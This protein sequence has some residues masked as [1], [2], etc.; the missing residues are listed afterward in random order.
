MFIFYNYYK[1]EEEHLSEQLFLEMKNYSFFFDD[2]R[3]DI[4]IVSNENQEQFYELYFNSKSLY[5]L[6]PLGD[7]KDS[8]LKIFYSTSEYKILLQNIQ[9]AIL[10]RFGFLSLIAIA[11]SFLF[12][13][14]ALHPLRQALQLL[15][16]F[17][18]DI[19]H[20]LNTPLTSILINIKM[21]DAKSE[22]V[23]SIA[24]SAKVISMLHKNLNLYLNDI[25]FEK[26]KFSLKEA[27]EEQALFFASMYDYLTWEIDVQ[28][29]VIATDRN[30]FGRIIYNLLSN[31]CK[32]NTSSGF[33]N[34]HTEANTLCIS[35]SSHGIKNPSK[36]FNR[37][38][39]E[40][41]RGLGIGLHVVEKLCQQLGIQKRL[42][43]DGSTVSIYL[44]LADFPS[45]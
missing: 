38:Y 30:A 41:D 9:I 21:M 17:I 18:K 2:E 34:I 26:E 42:E 25:H 36:I 22:E 3:F 29:R 37:F 14:Y 35:N 28:D 13:L 40:S 8:F 16:E 44:S 4:D 45:S 11:I 43:V 5:I 15:E 7:E 39:K 33:V 1:L 10:W 24:Q 31:A 27:V 32:Y 19:I 20:D 12:S 23:E 6:T